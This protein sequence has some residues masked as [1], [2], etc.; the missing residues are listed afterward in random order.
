MVR[1]FIPHARSPVG[2][3]TTLAFMRTKT[4]AVRFAPSRNTPHGAPIPTKRPGPPVAQRE[5]E[6]FAS[7]LR[8]DARTKGIP[9]Q[10]T[11][12]STKTTRRSRHLALLTQIAGPTAPLTPSTRGVL[13]PALHPSVRCR[14]PVHT[15]GTPRSGPSYPL[16][17][18]STPRRPLA[19]DALIIRTRTACAEGRGVALTGPAKPTE[20]TLR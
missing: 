18:G 16:G 17:N 14:T 9:T 10:G 5:T 4:D 1:P 2:T 19:P 6:P 11:P 20:A 13:V 8:A 12:P 15:A 3:Q 7:T